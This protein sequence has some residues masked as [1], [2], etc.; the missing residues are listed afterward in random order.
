MIGSKNRFG[1]A[2]KI[3]DEIPSRR[4]LVGKMPK[5]AHLPTDYCPLTLPYFPSAQALLAKPFATG[6]IILLVQKL[7]YS[8]SFG[9]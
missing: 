2:N 6:R 1:G 7:L 4:D 5:N 3:N 9:D 8:Y